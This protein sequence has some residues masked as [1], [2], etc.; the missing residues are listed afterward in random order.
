MAAPKFK[1][2]K[3]DNVQIIAGKDSGKRG[4][5]LRVLPERATACWSRS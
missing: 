3:D 2:K 1:I 4:K 5:V